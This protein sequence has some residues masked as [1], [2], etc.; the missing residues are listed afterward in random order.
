MLSSEVFFLYFMNK[1]SVKVDFFSR[2]R[3]CEFHTP[4]ENPSLHDHPDL[5]LTTQSRTYSVSKHKGFLKL[6]CS[7][8]SYPFQNRVLFWCLS[9]TVSD[10]RLGRQ[11]E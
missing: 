6:Y 7:N 4:P 1:D 10:L 11:Q 8:P 2:Y 9:C 3:D 5:T